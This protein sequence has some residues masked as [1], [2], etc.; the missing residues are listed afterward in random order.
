MIILRA[1]MSAKMMPP[2]VE[3]I[4]KNT[5]V[6]FFIVVL[7]TTLICSRLNDYILFCLIYQLKILR[8]GRLLIYHWK[9]LGNIFPVVYCMSRKKFKI[10]AAKRKNK[11]LRSFSDY[12]SG[13]SKKLQWENDCGSFLQCFFYLC[14]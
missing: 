14:T 13:W 2:L 9:G 10:A 3:N 4:V 8:I 5:A 12:R 11:N 7:L 6:V 1:E